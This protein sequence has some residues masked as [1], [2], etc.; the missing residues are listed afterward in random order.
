MVLFPVAY[1]ALY[2]WVLVTTLCEYVGCH[3][4]ENWI[5]AHT[6]SNLVLF[7][8]LS[9]KYAPWLW[10]CTK[11]QSPK[12]KLGHTAWL[13]LIGPQ[14][15]EFALHVTSV[16]Q[17]WSSLHHANQIFFSLESLVS[18]FLILGI[19]PSFEYWVTFVSLLVWLT[20]ILAIKSAAGIKCEVFYD[21]WIEIQLNAAKMTAPYALSFAFD[22]QST[23]TPNFIV[24]CRLRAG[25]ASPFLS[26]DPTWLRHTIG[27]GSDFNRN[28]VHF[29]YDV[30]AFHPVI[31]VSWCQVRR[32]RS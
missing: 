2:N 10:T 21:G 20:W 3:H 27:N 4:A 11:G 6:F 9:T 13:A 31:C 22:A 12:N 28:D 1:R 7:H 5:S 32:N 18:P 15:R 8:R 30:T 25:S 14:L 19:Y 23:N 24:Y 26:G 17:H 16:S 29:N